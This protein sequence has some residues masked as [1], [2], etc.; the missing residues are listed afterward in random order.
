MLVVAIVFLMYCGGCG[1]SYLAAREWAES[2][3]IEPVKISKRDRAFLEYLGDYEYIARDDD[4]ML[5]TYA[6]IPTKIF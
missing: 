3:Y 5:C 4:G 6:S 2:E 1:D